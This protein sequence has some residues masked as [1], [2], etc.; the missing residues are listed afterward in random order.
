MRNSAAALGHDVAPGRR[1][2]RNADAEERQ[3]RL[4]QDRVGA[5]EGALHDQRRDGVRQHVA[6]QQQRRRRAGRDR[7]LDVGLLAHRQH[8]RAHQAHHA[9]DLRHD[10]RDDDARAGRR[11]NSETSAIASRIAG[12]AIR[13]SISRM[14]M[15]VDPADVAGDQADDEP[16]R[17]ADHRDRD[18][19]EERDARA[20]DHAAVDVAAEAVG[21]HPMGERARRCRRRCGWSAR[22]RARGCGTAGLISDG[23]M[24]PSQR[25]RERRSATMNRM[26]DAR[27]R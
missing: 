2:G 10:D 8:D 14:T 21:A 4:D 26:I 5:D 25:R 6:E 19:D 27:R 17:D 1:L 18:A 20:V 15:R 23:F 3:D 9:R 7:R 11:R 22:C 13:P 24:V 16:D 12:I